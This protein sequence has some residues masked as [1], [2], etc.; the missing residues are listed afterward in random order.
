MLCVALTWLAVLMFIWLII[1][2][3]PL[4]FSA[5]SR[6]EELAQFHNFRIIKEKY[7]RSAST[8]T[9]FRWKGG[10]VAIFRILVED[11]NR[12]QL[13][14]WVRLGNGYMGLWSNR[15]EVIWKENGS[16][17]DFYAAGTGEF[18]KGCLMT[19]FYIIVAFL[20]VWVTRKNDM[21]VLYNGIKGAQFMIPVF[22][23]A[24]VGVFLWIR[25]WNWTLKKSE[26]SESK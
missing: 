24:F 8:F 12:N 15:C 11:E 10:P 20:F 4:Y 13:V 21:K 9:P 5:H 26:S 16:E 14:G 1:T 23:I 2:S 19:I 7:Y 6:L 3:L 25:D 18:F 22:I 17:Q